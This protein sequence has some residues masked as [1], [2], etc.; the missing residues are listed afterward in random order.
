M[1]KIIFISC[2]SAAMTV[3]L[4]SQDTNIVKY[5]PLK[6][7]NVWVY[8]FQASY[9]G[10][11]DAGYNKYRITGTTFVNG[12]TYFQFQK[13]TTFIY[14]GAFNCQSY[15]YQIDSPLRIDSI[16]GNIY[17][18]ANCPP[19]QLLDSL[20]SSL[21]DSKVTCNYTRICIDTSYYTIFSYTFPSKQLRNNQPQGG[22]RIDRYVKNIGVV[23]GEFHFNIGSCS[24]TL[25][26]CYL[27][28][29]LYG[30]TNVIVGLHQISSETPNQ[31]SLSQNYPNPFN[32]ETKIKFQVSKFSE[33]RIVIY[34][35][36]GR[37]KKILVNE[38]LKP[39][40]YEVNWDAENLSSG[41]Y[42]CK[43]TTDYLYQQTIKLSL[44]K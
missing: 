15:I 34:D 28:G 25:V 19:T 16:T 13:S 20:K 3:N 35:I 18:S 2:L 1:K 10:G 11:S 44:I 40:T 38:L 33:I 42:F 7:G 29:V 26:G 14:G 4:F 21:N 39:G 8:Y 32:P 30:D 36:L 5:F 37:E 27:D 12:R 9:K 6:V 22:Y 43:L 24:R 17:S 41:I 23:N 31:F